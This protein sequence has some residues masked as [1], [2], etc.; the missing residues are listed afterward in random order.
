MDNLEKNKTWKLVE[1]QENKNA[2]DVKWVYTKKS[3]GTFKA[4]LEVKRFQQE[5]VID[6]TYL[7]V[8]KMQT[9]KL[10]L[11]YCCQNSLII[12]QIDVETAFLNG[13]VVSEVYVK[14]TFRL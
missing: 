6:N 3:N 2:L 14:Q 10:L 5:E 12:E 9:L 4:R 8:F 7:P 13:K 1:L 11:S